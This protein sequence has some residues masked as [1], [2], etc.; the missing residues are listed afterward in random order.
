MPS[1]EWS[2]DVVRDQLIAGIL[3][4]QIDARHGAHGLPNQGPYAPEAPTLEPD[5]RGQRGSVP[6]GSAFGTGKV[7]VFPGNKELNVLVA[8]TP[9][10]RE[11]GVQNRDD[12]GMANGTYDGMVFQW[13]EDTQAALHNK[14]V[15]FPVSAAWFDSSGMYVDH[16]HLRPGQ[17]TPVSPKVSTGLSW[18]STPMTGMHWVWD[19]TH[20][21]RSP[22]LSRT[23]LPSRW[24]SV[25]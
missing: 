14:N 4:D 19:P 17:A 1:P 18:S 5:I 20:P 13:S 2:H 22:R 8:D 23:P 12:V 9:A 11:T 15:S 10:L 24:D 21:S 16:T 7:N 25:P 3:E 6:T